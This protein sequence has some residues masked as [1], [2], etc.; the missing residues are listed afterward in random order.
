M[1]KGKDAVSK[2]ASLVTSNRKLSAWLAFG[3]AGLATGA[4]WASGF[5]TSIADNR[6]GGTAGAPALAKTAP[7]TAT[8]AL[9]GKATDVDPLEFDW[10]GRWGSIDA[11]TVL[12]QVDLSASQFTGKH[13]NVATLLANT[14]DLSGWATLQ[15]KLELIA[16]A[17]SSCDV[18]DFAGVTD[19]QILNS[20]DQDAGVY[21]SNLAG[22]SVY[23]IGIK[24]AHGDDAAGT[25]L[26][27]ADDTP[28][29]HFPTFITT[30]DRT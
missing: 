4:V 8:T 25:F 5:A 18:T 17:G 3:A 21:W 15:L 12:F 20:D 14:S 30:V 1:Q 22:G 26:R 10:D 27:S 24:T 16:A 13:Y 29:T 7:T 23:C 9:N 11:T 19:P 6:T 28:P 2:L